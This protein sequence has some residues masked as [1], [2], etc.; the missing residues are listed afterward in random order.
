MIAESLKE[1]LK[2]YTD[3]DKDQTGVDI[4]KALEIML[5]KYDIIQ[6]MLYNHDHSDFESDKKSDR[7]NDISN[8]MDN[9]ISL[10]EEERQGFVNT[11]TIR[12]MCNRRSSSRIK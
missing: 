2:E 9:V 1:A 6:D 7:Y 8:T 4:D 3:S 12:F 11:V 5:M 10:G